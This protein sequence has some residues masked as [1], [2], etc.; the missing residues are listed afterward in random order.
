MIGTTPSNSAAP[1]PDRVGPGELMEGERVVWGLRLPKDA[2]VLAELEGLV[3]VE[4]DFSLTELEEYVRAR[5]VARHVEVTS[6][7][8]IFPEARIRGGDP[9][10]T[11]R[12][13]LRARGGRSE[14]LLKDITPLPP[15]PGLTQEE[16]WRKVGL[17]PK[18]Q[19][20]APDA[21]E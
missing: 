1:T 16:R 8:S 19:S 12:I 11:Y 17:T 14:L 13:E 20:V 2:R 21:L 7:R 4:G 18:A 9:D 15:T 3:K 5:V 6:E 10:R